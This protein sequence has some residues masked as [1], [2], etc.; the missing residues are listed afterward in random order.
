MTYI[1]QLSSTN[2]TLNYSRVAKKSRVASKLFCAVLT[3]LSRVV[4]FK[5]G[6]LL[7]HDWNH[8]QLGPSSTRPNANSAHEGQ[9]G[10]LVV[11]NSASRDG[12]VGP[13]VVVNSALGDGRV[14]P[15]PMVNSASRDG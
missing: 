15:L 12:R 9:V 10:P 14:G 2:N 5:A 6:G 7:P 4:G 13:L 8:S 11:V 1:S 3:S